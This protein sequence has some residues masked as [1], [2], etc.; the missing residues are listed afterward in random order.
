MMVRKI[1]IALLL[2][3]LALSFYGCSRNEIQ[4]S[5]E[6]REKADRITANC[7]VGLFQGYYGRFS[8]NFSD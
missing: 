5:P 6:V 1:I 7:L 3:L 8:R 2:L 4:L